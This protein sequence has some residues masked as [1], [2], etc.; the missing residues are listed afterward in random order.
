MTFSLGVAICFIILA[1]LS[2]FFGESIETVFI[3]FAISSIWY[4]IFLIEEKEK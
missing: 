1:I 2:F 4:V 3:F